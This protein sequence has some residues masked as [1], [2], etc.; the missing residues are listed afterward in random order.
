MQ[1]LLKVTRWDVV[2][3]LIIAGGVNIGMLL[4]AASALRGVPGTDTIDGAHAAIENSLGPGVAV[5]FAIG[6]LASGLASTSVGC[7]AAPRSCMVFWPFG[8]R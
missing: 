2:V 3:A 8:F 4:L 7:A 1:R 5:V 6:L